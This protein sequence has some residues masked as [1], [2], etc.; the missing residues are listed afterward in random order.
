[1]TAAPDRGLILAHGAGS[2]AEFLGRAFP[3]SACGAQTLALD[4]RT[5]SAARTAQLI[6]DAVS[7]VR[8]RFGRLYVGGVSIGAHAAALACAHDDGAAIDGCV[9]ALPAW[10]GSAD[11]GSATA[12]AAAEIEQRGTQAVLQRLG[13]DPSTRDDWVVQELQTAW[14]DRPTL[15][16]ELRTAALE[17]APAP[18]DLRGIRTPTLVLALADDPVHPLSVARQWAELIP[19]ARLT[20]LARDAPAA[21]RTVF[22]AAVGRWLATLSGPR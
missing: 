10:T 3:A 15:A 22:G 6:R 9:L 19:G 21:S 7:A 1:M 13:E 5:G 11:P 17:A 18:A 4:D 12:A 16:S 20:V 8:P 2:T 14:R